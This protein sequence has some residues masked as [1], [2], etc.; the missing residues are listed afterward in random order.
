[1]RIQSDKF[2]VIDAETTGTNPA[3]HDPVAIALVPISG[4]SEPLVVHICSPAPVWTEFARE[5]FERFVSTWKHEAVPPDVAAARIEEYIHTVGGGHPMTLIGHNVGFD[6]SFLRKLAAL[7]GKDDIAGLSHR[8][9]DTHS[10]LFCAWLEG[11]VPAEVLN[12]DGAFRHFRIP[13][14]NTLRHTALA[15]A[16]ATRTLFLH[17]VD[18]FEAAARAPETASKPQHEPQ[19]RRVPRLGT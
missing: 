16:L 7:A 14:E 12:S 17:L 13:V 1:M 18:L 8:T 2:L 15:D 10:L 5:N 11:R 9:L 6:L 3:L 4:T 19:R